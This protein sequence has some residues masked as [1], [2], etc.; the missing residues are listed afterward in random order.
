MVE[1]IHKYF[2]KS[3]LEFTVWN[4]VTMFLPIMFYYN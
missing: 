4:Q 1:S 2:S 3:E